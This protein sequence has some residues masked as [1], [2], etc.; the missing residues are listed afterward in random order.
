MT[1]GGGAVTITGLGMITPAGYGREATWHGVLG[2]V[3]TAATDQILKGLPVD[4]SCRVPPA[5]AGQGRIGGGKAWRMG[6]FAQLAV[7]AARE[8]VADAG[9]DPASW[10]GPR[11]GVVIGSSLAG[12]AHLED[13]TTRFLQMGPD[14]VSPLLIPMLGSNMAAGEVLLD[15]GARGPSLATESACAS[16]ASAV[17]VARD[18]LLS[19][20]CDIVLAGGTDAPITPVITSA[21]Q[22]L[23]TLSSRVEDP[24]GASQPFARDR[25]GFV[26]S[27]GAAVLVLERADDALARGRKGY[28]R[29]TGVGMTSDAHHPT[30]PA[31]DGAAAEAA[32]RTALAQAGLTPADVDHVNAHGTSTPLNDQIEAGLIARVLPHGPSVTSAKGVL[33]HSLGAAPA[34]EA[35]LTALSIEQGTVPPVANLTPETL[36]FPLQCVTAAPKRQS[37]RVA[38]SHSFGFGG[39]NVVLVLQAP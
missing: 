5:A 13:Q 2:G 17:G 26:M 15:L 39:H 32:L 37:I 30:S 38:V 31:P 22:R 3:S 28:A 25:D 18:L 36:G 10:E 19:G 8:A 7:L 4:F 9:L 6:R 23:G 24:S 1:V 14:L 35:A 34:I 20:A 21:F 16:G 12:A 29:L 33:G 11:V 27:E